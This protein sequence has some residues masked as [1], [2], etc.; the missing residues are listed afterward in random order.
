MGRG[1]KRRSRKKPR[2]LTVDEVL[3]GRGSPGVQE[4][5]DLIRRVNPTDRNLPPDQEQQRYRDKSALQ[6]ILISR[7]ADE[8]EVV[9]E[10]GETVLLRHR[11]SGR[12]ACHAVISE[13]DEE[14]R[15]WVR[16][17]LDEQE[18]EELQGD[19]S[20]DEELAM[21]PQEQMP[22]TNI[23]E[24]EQGEEGARDED[25]EVERD[26]ARL[27]QLG[28]EAV[29]AYDYEQAREYFVLAFSRSRGSL[30]VALPLLELLV[31]CLADFSG[32]L[33]LSQKFSQD[34]LRDSRVRVLLAL[35]A[36]HAAD[37]KLATELVSGLEGERVSEVWL[38]LASCALVAGDD[39]R[40]EE[41]MDAA[42]QRGAAVDELHRLEQELVALR[43][44]KW[45]GAEQEL[46]RTFDA[47]D[48]EAAEE[49]ARDLLERWPDS[50]EARRILRAINRQQRRERIQETLVGAREAMG[51]REYSA[52][53]ELY[54]KARK[55]GADDEIVESG[56]VKARK[57][58]REEAD[59]REVAVVIKQLDGQDLVRA[60]TI[61]RALSPGLRA[62]VRDRCTLPALQWL[63]EIAPRTR[64]RDAVDAVLA[65]GRAEE[66]LERGEPGAVQN[67]LR[68]HDRVLK[69][70]GSA[71]QI[72]KEAGQRIVQERRD[73]ACQQLEEAENVFKAGD[74]E[75]ARD[76]LVAVEGQVLDP[77]GNE[78]L[79]EMMD[80][81]E[82]ELLA[83]ESAMQIRRIPPVLPR[84]GTWA[85]PSCSSR[86]GVVRGTCR[87]FAPFVGVSSSSTPHLFLARQCWFMTG[88]HDGWSPWPPA[89]VACRLPRWGIPPPI[90]GQLSLPAPL[91]HVSHAR[92]S[93]WMILWS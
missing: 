16:R 48:V 11:P 68:P 28:H 72:L 24:A 44:R 55:L 63:D 64:P 50:E 51:R 20:P 35:S 70:V 75:H 36:A 78:R 92:L 56:L 1:R 89:T 79:Q 84:P 12:D 80:A 52:A 66:A 18:Y 37:Q 9:V 4:F 42:R 26:P 73:T 76:L 47:G 58:A 54:E 15:R 7:F 45:E 27:V 61:Y 23:S 86:P 67:L 82:R 91:C 21:L 53:I 40:A 25:Q 10:E 88:T 74:L 31:D 46:R 87:P 38:L 49:M 65:L 71:R 93:V 17:Q 43:A 34:T 59:N 33:A 8:L 90:C 83:R 2:L 85:L 81:M 13:L 19:R 39:G 41:H 32:A 6:G 22:S 69:R 77:R 3:E 30:E 29:E 57:L 60:L 5:I 62:R 14:A